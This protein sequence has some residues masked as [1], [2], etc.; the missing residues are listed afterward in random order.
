MVAN[1]SD[2]DAELNDDY[3]TF[4]FHPDRRGIFE[5]VE[6]IVS[7][8]DYRRYIDQIIGLLFILSVPVTHNTLTTNLK[9]LDLPYLF[10]PASSKL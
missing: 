10:C 3:I 5:V 4:I 2:D 6:R 9:T 1:G 8:L 7:F